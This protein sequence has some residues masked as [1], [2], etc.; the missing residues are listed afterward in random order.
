MLGDDD[1]LT[2]RLCEALGRPLGVDARRSGCGGLL[3]RVDL[4]SGAKLIISGLSPCH[5]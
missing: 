4:G 5:R 2:S 3:G 1:P